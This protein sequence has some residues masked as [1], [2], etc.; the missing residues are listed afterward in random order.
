MNKWGVEM[1]TLLGAD[2]NMDTIFG[3]GGCCQNLQGRENF[4]FLP[5]VG[6]T[7]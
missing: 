1:V 7:H 2:V 5:P 6:E 3:A 4:F